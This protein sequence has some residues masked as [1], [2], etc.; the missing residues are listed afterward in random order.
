MGLVVP[1]G[2]P[3]VKRTGVLVQG[4]RG[5]LLVS[6]VRHKK[7]ETASHNLPYLVYCLAIVK[8]APSC[9]GSRKY[10]ALVKARLAEPC[11]GSM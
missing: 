3:Y 2:S 4:E 5:K 1:N 10:P 7:G 11:P 8:L 6:I 9:M